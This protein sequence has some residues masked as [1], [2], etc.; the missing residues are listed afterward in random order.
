MEMLDR[1]T[2][3]AE[4]VEV[5]EVHSEVTV[6]GYEANRL[7]SS[8]V[9]ETRGLA[10]RVVKDG[11]LGFSA[12]TDP[13]AVDKLVTNVLESAAYGDEVPLAF[14]APQPAPPVTRQTFPF[15]LSSSWT[16]MKR[17]SKIVSLITPTPSATVTRPPTA[18]PAR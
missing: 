4:Q 1:L 3:E 6:V 5:V 14:P 16:C 17:F 2:A 12:S 15:K 7:K 8:R 13:S 10:V 9:E 18:T 11:R